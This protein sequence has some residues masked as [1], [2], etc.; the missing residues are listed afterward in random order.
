MTEK[1]DQLE[2]AR[3]RDL[4]TKHTGKNAPFWGFTLVFDQGLGLITY[5]V[6]SVV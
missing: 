6:E 1:T 4:M 2:Q 3:V 5:S